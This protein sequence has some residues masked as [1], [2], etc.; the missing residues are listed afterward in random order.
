MSKTTLFL[1]SFSFLL[2]PKKSKTVRRTFLSISLFYFSPSLF[3]S[4]S[5]SFFSLETLSF[6]FF[7]FSLS[8]NS[9]KNQKILLKIF[10]NKYYS[11]FSLLSFYFRFVSLSFWW[12]LSTSSSLWRCEIVLF[13]VLGL[14]RF[15]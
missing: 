8:Q 4:L 13:C 15:L 14:L 12:C 2:K 5:F 11:Y 6:L 7:L 10:Y 1:F 9:Q 3:F